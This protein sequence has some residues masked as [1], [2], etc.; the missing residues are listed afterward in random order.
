MSILCYA[1]LGS[2]MAAISYFANGA[3]VLC[4]AMIMLMLSLIWE[5][6]FCLG[7][8]RLIVHCLEAFTT[9]HTGRDTL[10]DFYLLFLFLIVLLIPGVLPQALLLFFFLLF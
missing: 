1:V 2:A 5:P 6:A 10:S 4:S 9:G 8:N 3:R 7:Y